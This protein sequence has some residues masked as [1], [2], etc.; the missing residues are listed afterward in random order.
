M[1]LSIV[2]LISSDFA[3]QYC[4]V[5]VAGLTMLDVAFVRFYFESGPSISNKIISRQR[6][7]RKQ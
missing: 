5:H 3:K 2:L 1:K 7:R 6:N 4:F